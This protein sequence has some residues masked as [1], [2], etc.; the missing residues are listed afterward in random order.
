MT[1]HFVPLGYHV[2]RC[3]KGGDR[4]VAWHFGLLAEIVLLLKVG[5]VTPVD[6]HAIA[7]AITDFLNRTGQLPSIPGCQP[8][9]QP[10]NVIAFPDLPALPVLP[11]R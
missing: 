4:Q 6:E 3:T 9:H 11:I 7:E 1:F 10:T 5:Y 2:K 8:S